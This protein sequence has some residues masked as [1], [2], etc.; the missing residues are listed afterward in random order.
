MVVGC[1]SIGSRHL[2]NL[3]SLKIGPLLAYDPDPERA[4]KASAETGAT[5]LQSLERAPELEAAFICSP[6]SLHL[7]VA[8]LALDRGAH[9]FIE[10]PLSH[11]LDGIRELLEE[12]RARKRIVMVGFNLRFHPCLQTI[13]RLLDEGMVGRALAARI[14]FGQYLPDWHPWE[15]YRKG[16]SANRA[17]GGG[18]IL[19]AV[20]EF[21]YA[22]WLLGN[23]EAVSG[24]SGTVGSLEIDTEDIGAFILRHQGGA[25]SEIHLDYLQRTYG[26]TCKVI[27]SEG[28]I[29]WDWNERVVKCFQ[30]R[31]G[32]WELL[33]EP[34]GYDENET[35]LDETRQF[36]GAIAGKDM[37]AVDGESGARVLAVA[38]AAKEAAATGRTVSL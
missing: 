28:T 38:L 21:D 5:V 13:K 24:M 19:D 25:V 35:Y 14:E 26:R 3:V 4:S 15:D 36:F 27:G 12:S 2:R 32:R 7:E 31:T 17:L 20:H 10:K 18:I 34:D 33:P 37:P 30:G 23:I 1:G 9:L 6:T 22:G 11:S 29:S 8:R 16:Y